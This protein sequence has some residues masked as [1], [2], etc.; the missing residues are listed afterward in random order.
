M[1]ENDRRPSVIAID[2]P[3]ASGKSTIGQ[4]LAEHLGYL[5]LD[6]GCMYRAVA[7]AAI[8][9]DIDPEDEQAV[10]KLARGL[11]LDVRPLAEE[12][13]GRQ[14]T[15]VLDGTDVTW[16]IRL[17]TVDAYVSLVSSYR[18]VRD[19]MVRR[20]R[21]FGRRGFVVMVGRDIGTVVMPD[22]PLKFFVTASP[23]VRANRR[24]LDRIAQGHDADV[25]RILDEVNRRDHFDRNRKHSPLRPASDAI[26]IDTSAYSQEAVL[27]EVLG[28]IYAQPANSPI[29]GQG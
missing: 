10:T 17:P 16:D 29:S 2:G 6:T 15:V 24:Y 25:N 4:M 3:A 28:Y 1:E 22:A 13:D 14:Y 12:I 9:L 5:Y 26:Q 11:N 27:A 21:E 19:E 23:E 20:Q 18:G 8:N 7:L